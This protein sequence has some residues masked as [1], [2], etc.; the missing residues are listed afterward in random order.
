MKTNE[1]SEP[2]R[3]VLLDFDG[4]ITEPFFDWKAIKSEMGIGEKLVLEA[5]AEAAPELRAEMQAVMDRW[6]IDAVTNARI[7]D[8][9]PALLD[10][11]KRLGISSAVVTNNCSANVEKVAAR[12]GLELPPLVSRDCGHFKPSPEIIALALERTGTSPAGTAFVGD[13]RLDMITGRNS[14]LRTMY[15]GNSPAVL[16]G[17]E[18]DYYISDIPSLISLLEKLCPA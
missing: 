7:R 1:P 13:S 17:V 8:G 3:G 4:T 14:G 10:T 16:E 11:L 12:F 18:P 9:V 15:I 6:E 2:L 5:M